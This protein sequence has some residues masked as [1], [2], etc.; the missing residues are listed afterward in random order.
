MKVILDTDWY[1]VLLCLLLGAAY[2]A[3]LYFLG[4]RG[5]MSARLRWLLAVVR[6][7]AVSLI[8][9]LL[10][11]PL[12]KR[13]TTRHEKP[14]VALLEDRSRSIYLTRDSAYYR[15][16]FAADLDEMAAKMEDDYDVV[17]IPF[18]DQST[19]IAAALSKV[20]EQYSGRN[21]G[22][23]MLITDGIYNEGANPATAVEGLSAPVYCVALGDTAVRRDAALADIRVNRTAYLGNSFPLEVTVR[24]NRMDGQRRNLTIEHEGHTVASRQLQFDGPS[25]TIA[26]TFVLEADKAGLQRYTINLSP[27]DGE[28]ITANNHRSVTVDVI[29]GRQKIAIVPAAPHPDVAAL[30]AAIGSNAAYEAKIIKIDDLKNL[31]QLQKDGYN[32]V[33]FHNLPNAAHDLKGL[34]GALPTLFV[35]GAQT[36]LPRFNALHQGL[37]IVT[38]LSKQTEAL[39]VWNRDFGLFTLD[40]DAARRIEQ[41]PPLSAPFGDY[42]LG[43]GTQSLLT[44]KVGQVVSRQP[45]A[46]FSSQ[47]EARRGFI[48]GEGLWRWRLA[49]YRLNNSHETFNTLISKMLNFTALQAVK[50]QFHI[51]A[52]A[53]YR[54]DEPVVIGAELYNDSYEP[55]NT[56]EATIVVKG[57]QQAEYTFNRAGTGYTLNLGVLPAGHYTYQGATTMNGRRLTSAGA[58]V[59]EELVLE[60]LTLTADH[61]LLATIAATTGGEVLEPSE[62]SSFSDIIKQ[63]DD[64]K[65]VIYSQTRYSELIGLP[66]VFVLIML[67]LGAEWV[68][69]KYNGEV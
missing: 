51:N 55:V 52:N 50:E 25:I 54:T 6:F 63:R 44:A 62:I 41:W 2:A 59:V 64:I 42:R 31:T 57:E 8:A 68:A 60:E 9:L 53:I 35:I 1:Y 43:G 30:A 22:A 11:A 39:P 19:D 34:P 47:G 17:R 18:G 12:A 3:V 28:A 66:W 37:E 40:D 24:A 27:T 46:A 10:L 61:S 13:E 33:I 20:H 5:E 48:A 15:T 23:V 67:L 21:L 16:E 38:K 29:D 4:R 7:L 49:D 58:F 56:P 36:D 65:S 14:V 26:E 69:R 32:L 45:V